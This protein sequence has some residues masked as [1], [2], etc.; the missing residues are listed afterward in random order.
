VSLALGK[1]RKPPWYVMPS[2]LSP[3]TTT[4]SRQEKSTLVTGMPAI[5]LGDVL[6][7]T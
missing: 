6:A 7:A 3:F 4:G 5:G 2:P 1:E